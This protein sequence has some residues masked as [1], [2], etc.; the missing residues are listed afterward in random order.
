MGQ[1]GLDGDIFILGSGWLGGLDASVSGV[2]R[3]GCGYGD[4]RV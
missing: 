4:K 2:S 3:R 1:D